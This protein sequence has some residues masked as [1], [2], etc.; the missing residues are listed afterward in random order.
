MGLIFCVHV[1]SVLLEVGLRGSHTDIIEDQRMQSLKIPILALKGEAFSCK[2]KDQE[3]VTRCK[4]TL[5]RIDYGA[6]TVRITLKP[7]EYLS[8]FWRSTGS[9]TGLKAE[10]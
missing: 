5:M 2:A 1:Y 6:K 9:C 4:I 8:I 3:E 7:G 10:L